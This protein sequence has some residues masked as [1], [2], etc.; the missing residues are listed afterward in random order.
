MTAADTITP[1]GRSA[2]RQVDIVGHSE[3]SLMPNHY[4]EFLGGHE[5]VDKYIGITPLS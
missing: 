3:G 4:V 2:L 1:G 5:R